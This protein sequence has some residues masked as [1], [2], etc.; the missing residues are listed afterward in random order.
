MRM[1][2]DSGMR[3]RWVSREEG[4]HYFEWK[5]TDRNSK[6]LEWDVRKWKRVQ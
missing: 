1:V 3:V 5:M 6:G 4:R 2:G